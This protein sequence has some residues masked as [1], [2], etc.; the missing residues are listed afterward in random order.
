MHGWGQVGSADFYSP[1]LY[2]DTGRNSSTVM[3]DTPHMKEQRAGPQQGP[4]DVGAGWRHPEVLLGAF[5]S[6]AASCEAE[7]L[8][9]KL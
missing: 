3:V 2:T 6:A 9:N 1:H 4:G 7:L 5:L 8:P